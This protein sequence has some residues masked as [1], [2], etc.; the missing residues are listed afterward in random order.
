MFY[1]GQH[2]QLQIKSADSGNFAKV[3]NLKNWSINFTMPVLDTTC[4]EDT[5]RTVL[6][7]VRSFSGQSSL[8][9]YSENNSNLRLM[10]RDLIYG[11]NKGSNDYSN[12]NFGQATEPELSHLILRLWDGATR[13]ISVFAYITS[14]TISCQVGEVVTADLSFEGHGSPTD[15]DMIL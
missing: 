12:K 4:L 9:Y 14:F 13:D 10:T 1:S 8:L 15:M 7:G 6:H 2:G 3:G 11:K 5:D